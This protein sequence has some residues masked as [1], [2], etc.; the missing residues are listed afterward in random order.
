VSRG[1]LA[2]S[3]RFTSVWYR[4]TYVYAKRWKTN[5]L[6]PLLEPFIYLFGLGVGVG[7]F[8]DQIEGVDYLVYV[9]P[10][11]VARPPSCAPPSSAPTAPTSAWPSRAPSTASSR[12]RST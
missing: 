8:I 5:L 6:P 7:H 1:L 2:V 9:A 10:G 3:H 11:I 4:D 12:P